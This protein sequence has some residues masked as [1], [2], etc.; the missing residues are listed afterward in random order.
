MAATAEVFW[1]FFLLG[2]VGFGGPAA[3]IGYFRSEF[4]E[5]RRWLSSEDY[6]DLVSLSQFLPGPGSSQVGFAIGYRRAGLAGALAAFL[7]FTLPAFGLMFLAAL[8]YTQLHDHAALPALLA[9][10]KLLAAIV[11][12]DA[13]WGMWK[14]SA[15]GLR[16]VL[17]LVLVAVV[18][19]LWPGP[20]SQLGSMAISA[21][22][23]F[24]LLSSVA[25]EA[26]KLQAPRP[27]PLLIFVGILLL[28][29]VFYQ[30][31]DVFSPFFA[32]GSMVFGGGHV[33]LPLLQSTVAGEMGSGEFLAGYAAAQAVPGPMFSL[34]SYLGAMLRPEQALLAALIATAGVFL[35]GLLLMLSFEGAWASLKARPRLAAAVAGVNTGVIG[36]LLAA[37][38]QPVLVSAIGGWAEA[39]LVALGIGLMQRWRPPIWSLVLV[40]IAVGALLQFWP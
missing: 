26:G 29:V 1:R 28:V 25:E 13:I 7:G 4:V 8:S 22:F 27:I 23:G 37:W 11:V 12:A 38:Y 35:P 9:G 39:V 30:Q 32:A 16:L 33:V 5:R 14:A 2:C 31:L 21:A 34:A 20:L 36:L 17:L 18:N 24:Y 6:A 3:H 40:A 15:G 10:L 19:S